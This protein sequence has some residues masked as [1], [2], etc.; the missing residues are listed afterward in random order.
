MKP[1][2]V[3]KYGGMCLATPEKVRDVAQKVATISRLGHPLIVIVSAMG[4]TTD[5]LIRLAYQVSSEPSRRELD[6]L[7]TTG[8]RVSMSLLSMALKDLGIEALSLT[9]SQAGV[10]TDGSHSN[11]KILDVK[12]TRLQEELHKG[13]VIVLAGFQGVDPITKEITTLG[14]GGSDTTAVAIAAACQAHLCEI[15][16]EVKG[17]CSADPRVVS[18]PI[19]YQKMSHASLLEMCFWGAKIL[20]Y[21]SVELAAQMKVPLSL[22][23]AQDANFGTLISTEVSM[24]E[25]QKILAVNSHQEVHHFSVPNVESSSDG[26]LVFE[27]QLQSQQL[28]LPQILAST[29]EN[30]GLRVMYTSDT[31]HLSA[32][33]RAIGLNQQ[34]QIPRPPLSSVTLTCYG[35]VAS[36]LCSSAVHLLKSHGIAV[37][38]TVMSPMSLTL[39]IQPQAREQSIKVLHNLIKK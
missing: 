15:V 37:E 3:Q 2:I 19:V 34:I 17:L 26:F 1:L 14:R 33:Q 25:N 39:L 38:K 23:F 35:S 8:E 20:H 7:L 28:P 27:N 30:G 4:K 9:G 36:D 5:E 22:S 11:A 32:I 13:K 10:F 21:R 31:E 12:P 18:E 16:K 24:F 29:F 6:M